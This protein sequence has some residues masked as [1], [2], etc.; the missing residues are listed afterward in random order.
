MMHIKTWNFNFFVNLKADVWL[1]FGL[2]INRNGATQPW[3][4]QCPSSWSLRNDTTSIVRDSFFAEVQSQASQHPPQSVQAEVDLIS[5]A[6]KS[7]PPQTKFKVSSTQ[8][9]ET[10]SLFAL[11]RSVYILCERKPDLCVLNKRK[12]NVMR[13]KY[14]KTPKRTW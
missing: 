14:Y 3:S 7:T 2:E 12:T 5:G 4:L 8:K 13:W 1:Y 10:W 9:N 6:Q 11:F